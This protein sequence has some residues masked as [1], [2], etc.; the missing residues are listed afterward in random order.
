MSCK[1][2][3][4]FPF[5]ATFVQ[6]SYPDS[7]TPE[8]A[9]EAPIVDPVGAVPATGYAESKWLGERI[10]NASGLTNATVVRIGQLSS[11]ENGYWNEKE[12]FPALVKSAHLVGCLPDWDGVRLTMDRV[13]TQLTLRRGS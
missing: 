8:P 11:G 3:V 7:T 10:I 1:V 5:C 4:S 9:L 13:D 6:F 2:S 12:W